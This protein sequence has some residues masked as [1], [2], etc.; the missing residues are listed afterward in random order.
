MID[1]LLSTYNGK[2]YI[3]AFLQSLANQSYTDWR[4]LVRDDGSN[5]GTLE[6]LESIT[7][8]WRQ[9]VKVLPMTTSH[10]GAKNSF[11]QLMLVSNGEYCAFADQDDVWLEH[12]LELSMQRMKEMEVKY[13]SE[14]ALIVHSD[15]K[16]VDENLQELSP[17]FWKYSNLRPDILETDVHY[18]GVTNC[19]T[20][21][22]M[23]IN[24]EAR[25]LSLPIPD[26]A[27]M[28]DAWIGVKVLSEGGKINYIKDSTLFY[29]QHGDNT[30]GAIKYNFSVLNW[31]EKYRLA[32]LSYHNAK[33]IVFKNKWHFLYWKCRYF[34]RLHVCG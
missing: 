26:N 7:K 22:T 17:S 33:G 23:L 14:R 24:R 20:G 27:Y 28:H 13:G 5:D 19:L 32:R 11:E 1:I 29:R 10:I 3:A 18:L 16:V 25:R 9:E 12:K 31:H 6:I 8:D 2:T 15:M 30:L 21:C 4:L 34:Y